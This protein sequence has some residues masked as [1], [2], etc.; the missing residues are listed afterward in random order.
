LVPERTL[1]TGVDGGK[2]SG[3]GLGKK[4]HGNGASRRQRRMEGGGEEARETNKAN[5]IPTQKG[6]S[7]NRKEATVKGRGKRKPR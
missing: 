3:G 6:E 4:G 2:E 1:G 7:A 5:A